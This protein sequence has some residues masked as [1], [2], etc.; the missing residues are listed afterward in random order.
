MIN[1]I[2]LT[3]VMA[4][5]SSESVF[6]LTDSEQK[7]VDHL[8]MLFKQNHPQKIALSIQYPLQREAPIPAIQNT[9]EME[10]RFN[11]VFDAQ[12]KQDIANSQLSQWSSMGW[13][14]LM[15]DN[16]KV[17]LDGGKIT[18]VNYS[19]KAEQQYKQDLIAQQKQ[20]LHPSLQKFRAPVFSFNTQSFMVRIDELSS[21]QYRYASWKA[22]QKQAAKPSLI[23]NQ[24]S[25][26]F[27]GSGGNHYYTFKSGS[28]IYTVERI[29]MGENT[30]PEVILRVK[31]RNKIILNQTGKLIN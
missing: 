20:Q 24:G 19:S 4:I 28:N 31:Q 1:K 5:I 3:F 21:G 27:D 14:G 17:W 23:L 26:T 25:V 18:A 11:Q 10:K 30:A 13:R 22:N 6:A 8:V 9:A 2:T 12:L 29:V 16:G 15:L 7:Q